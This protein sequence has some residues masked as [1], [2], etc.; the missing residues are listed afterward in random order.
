[1]ALLAVNDVQ[2]W[3][4]GPQLVAGVVQELNILG[5]LG[6]TVHHGTITDAVNH[7]SMA[8]S[9]SQ[10]LQRINHVSIVP[11][12][13]EARGIREDYSKILTN[14]RDEMARRD[15]GRQADAIESMQDG[16]ATALRCSFQFRITELSGIRCKLNIRAHDKLRHVV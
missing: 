4:G 14:H 16:I 15:E 9:L 1:M 13:H 7:Q 10:R 5:Y 12:L 2:R 11:V 3:A 6:H 8:Q